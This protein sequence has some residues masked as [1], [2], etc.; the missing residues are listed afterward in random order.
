MRAAKPRGH[1]RDPPQVRFSKTLSW[2][3]R[4]AA[5]TEGL[6]MRADGYLRVSELVTLLLFD[7][8]QTTNVSLQVNPSKATNARL[9]IVAGNS[10]Q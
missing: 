9:C 1:P 5:K 4:H 6:A 7:E 3:L 10:K 2:L 8:C